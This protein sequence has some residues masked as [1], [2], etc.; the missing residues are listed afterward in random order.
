MSA[1]LTYLTTILPKLAHRMIRDARGRGVT[2]HTQQGGPLILQ[3]CH[4]DREN[5]VLAGLVTRDLDRLAAALAL[6]IEAQRELASDR[7]IPA[8]VTRWPRLV[9]PCKAACSSDRPA[10]D[11]LEFLGGEV[12][13]RGRGNGV[14][15]FPT[16]HATERMAAREEILAALS[17]ALAHILR[18]M[19]RR[20]QH[21]RMIRLADRCDG[22]IGSPV[23]QAME[24]EAGSLDAPDL[25][26]QPGPLVG[27]ARMKATNARLNPVVPP[28]AVATYLTQDFADDVAW[29][30]NGAPEVPSCDTR[31]ANGAMILSPARLGEANSRIASWTPGRRDLFAVGLYWAVL[32]DQA[33]YTWRRDY[34]AGWVETLPAP[35]PKLTGDCPGGCGSHQEPRLAI[36]FV[37]TSAEA[38]TGGRVVERRT[39]LFRE[40]IPLMRRSIVKMLEVAGIPNPEEVWVNLEPHFP[41]RPLLLVSLLNAMA[42]GNPACQA[43]NITPRGQQ[44]ERGI[45]Q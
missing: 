17:P 45:T 18:A 16:D 30:R 33:V 29:V 21:D 36:Q 39:R 24:E 32:L 11:L 7:I 40:S 25:V 35:F 1:R 9:G 41:A 4:L 20:H 42:E 28:T 43:G 38:A 27:K 15:S 3:P 10:K 34:H 14:P 2:H 12:H 5:P 26:F 31:W 6:I 23:Q 37:L 44:A 22:G 8:P 19:G 13:G